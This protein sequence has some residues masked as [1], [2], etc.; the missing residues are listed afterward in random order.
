MIRHRLRRKAAAIRNAR[1][2]LCELARSRLSAR[3]RAKILFSKRRTDRWARRIVN[4]FRGTGHEIFFRSFPEENLNDY[5]LVVPI[6]I[7]H[8]KFLAASP[9][10]LPD[11][12]IPVTRMEVL[13]LC[14]NKYELNEALS[15]NG[16]E[17]YLPKM[18]RPLPYPYILKKRIDEWGRN[19]H[20]ITDAQK[21]QGL[22]HLIDDPEY[23]CQQFIPGP[24]EYAT[25]MV[26]RDGRLVRS[27]NVRYGFT[28][29]MPVKGPD[30]EILKSI[31]PCPYLEVF[32]DALRS[33]SFEGLCNV[34]YKVANGQ[35]YIFEINPRFGGSLCPF[36]FSFVRSL[37]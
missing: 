32:T 9:H 20:T 36:F 24:N 23:L 3:P 10:L 11:H 21:E 35:P 19:I 34:N 30:T 6:A 12:P 25:H 7:R 37:I 4:S 26:I 33:I 13:D 28:T 17:K 29:D 16:F 14:D 15:A 31:C 8:L 27:L 2:V 1:Y 18:G 5:D 22:S